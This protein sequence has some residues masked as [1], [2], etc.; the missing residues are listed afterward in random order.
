V[1]SGLFQR[2]VPSFRSLGGN[3]FVTFDEMKLAYLEKLYD[4]AHEN[5]G[6]PMDSREYLMG[7]LGLDLHAAQQLVRSLADGRLVQDARGMGAPRAYIEPDGRTLV[8]RHRIHRNNPRAREQAARKAFLQFAADEEHPTL[9]NFR[10]SQYAQWK[11]TEFTEQE[12]QAAVV[13]LHEK[14]LVTSR[15]VNGPMQPSHAIITADGR[16]CLSEADGDVAAFLR[17]SRTARTTVNN[18]IGVYNQHGGNNAVGSQNVTQNATTG[19]DM[20][21]L[22]AFVEQLLAALPQLG[23][24]DDETD[25]RA[26]LE[27]LRAEVTTE[28]PEPGRVRSAIGKFMRYIAGA[29]SPVLTA[30]FL[31]A[32]QSGGL[33][34]M[35]AV[36]P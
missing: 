22:A 34:P 3:T 10:Q 24:G 9:L 20:A 31:F 15:G 4:Y 27:K 28:N 7:E 32:A 21:Q 14:G 19:T 17:L 12:V 33:L 11:S 13:Y 29:G 2:A 35:P 16:D 6:R 30:F 8:E 26:E 5:P 25:A 36:T 18:S 1:A 23:L